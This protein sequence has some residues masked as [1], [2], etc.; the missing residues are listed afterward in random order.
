MSH[1]RI[2]VSDLKPKDEVKSVYMVKFVSLMEAKDGKKYGN[3]IFSDGTGEIEGRIWNYAEELCRKVEKGYFV[4]VKGKVNYFQGRRQIIV[5]MLEQVHESEIVKDDFIVKSKFSP[6]AMFEQLMSIVNNL[7]DAYIRALLQNILQDYEI[8]RR[9]KVW[10]AGKTI[11]HAYQ[12]GLLEH[13]LS[14]T[15]LGLFLSKHYNVNEN[16]VVAGT[17]LHDICKIYELTDGLNVEYTEE[18]KLVGHLV[19]ALEIVDRFSYKI[20]TFPHTTKMHLKHILL[21]HHGEYEYGSPKIPSTSEAYLVHLIDMMDSKM[22]TIELIKRLDPTP[23]HWSG[24]IRHMDRI[25]Y[26]GELPF[27]ETIAEEEYSEPVKSHAPVQAKAAKPMATNS[28]TAQSSQSDLKQNLGALL[29]DFKIK[30]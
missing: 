1:Q 14:C 21:S 20:K 18:G 6:E 16:Y 9:L 10:Q 5:E 17:I 7:T 24:Y 11:H 29:K 12:S 19:K 22:N 26:K 4:K 15:E 2:N 25:V 13:I 28:K 3:I 8:Q 27:H 30:D 23:G